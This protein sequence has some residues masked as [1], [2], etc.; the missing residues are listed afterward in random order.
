LPFV[1][2][3]LVTLTTP[4]YMLPL[5]QTP[6]GLVWLGIAALL[7]GTGIFVMYRMVQFDF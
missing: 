3:I 7:M 4:G 1:V 5:I 6:I 2:A